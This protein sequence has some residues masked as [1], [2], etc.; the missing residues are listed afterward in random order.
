[1]KLIPLLFLF[2]ILAGNASAQIS[3][4]FNRDLENNRVVKPEKSIRICGPSRAGIIANSP[5][6]VVNDI[7]YFNPASISAI[8]PNGIESLQ[9]FSYAQVMDK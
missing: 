4:A 8:D 3:D 7:E 2:F 6:Y 1:M 9:V 5:L